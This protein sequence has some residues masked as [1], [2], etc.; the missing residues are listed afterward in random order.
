MPGGQHPAQLA[1]EIGGNKGNNTYDNQGFSDRPGPEKEKDIDGQ[2]DQTDHG[3]ED[4]DI[5]PIQ[6]H[7]LVVIE[8]PPDIPDDQVADHIDP[9]DEKD[10]DPDVKVDRATVLK[11]FERIENKN[12]GLEDKYSV[13][14]DQQDL[15]HGIPLIPV[16]KRTVILIGDHPPKVPDKT[17][18][19]IDNKNEKQEAQEEKENLKPLRGLVFKDR[20]NFWITLVRSY[21]FWFNQRQVCGGAIR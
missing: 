21:G 16:M 12:P 4:A 10:R 18:L 11:N 6:G 2:Q 17:S 9:E 7:F 8:Q 20:G 14:H 19:H 1:H 3:I 5:E 13:A 15:P